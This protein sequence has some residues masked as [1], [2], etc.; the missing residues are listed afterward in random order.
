MR[1]YDTALIHSAP[2]PHAKLVE[3]FT[4]I[5]DS[6]WRHVAFTYDGTATHDGLIIYIDGSLASVTNA[7]DTL[8]TTESILN[9]VPVILG[10]REGGGQ[11]STGLLDE[12]R[13][14]SG[15]LTAGEVAALVVPEPS[16]FVLLGIGLASLLLWRRRK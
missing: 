3:T 1:G 10:A 14:Y 6:T 4:S 9:D 5:E 12:V 2:I 13:I 15:V 11:C 16:T 7:A 8:E